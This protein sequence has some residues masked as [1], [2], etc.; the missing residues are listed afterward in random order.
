MDKTELIN[1][2][3]QVITPN[4]QKA[5]TAESLANLLIE[6]VEAMGTGSGSG[7]G[8]VVF[9][10]GTP[11]EDFS[12]YTQTPEQKAHNAEM[13]QIVRDS[14]FAPLT[15]I[16]FT[17]LLIADAGVDVD[18]TGFKASLLV[19]QTTFY[20]KQVAELEGISDELVLLEG[21]VTVCVFSDGS[22]QV[23]GL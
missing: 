2:I 20:P 14:Q 22:V 7:S 8:Q 15:S 11:N 21:V 19:S 10:I 23:F 1:A 18:M 3:Q 13:F 16:D 4:N 6:V 17:D 9:Y 5:I 12:D